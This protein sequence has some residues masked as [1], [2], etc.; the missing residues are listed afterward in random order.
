MYRVLCEHKFSTPLRKDQGAWWLD[1]VV[2]V[3]LDL[4]ETFKPSAKVAVH[5]FSPTSSEW[6]FL[7]FRIFASMHLVLSVFWI[8]SHSNR[9]VVSSHFNLHFPD[10]IY[11]ASFHVL[12]CHLYI[13]FGEVSVKVF[14]PFYKRDCLLSYSVL[15]VFCVFWIT[16]LYQMCL[17]QVFFP[18]YG[19]SS[20]S[21]DIVF[22]RA[23]VFIYYYY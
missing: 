22:Y 21:L 8:F 17:L 14:G 4:K 5:F 15:R 13:F 23:E 19:L 18:Y 12:I 2:R 10:G 1:Y 20:N 9:C 3:F 11:G 16:V 6:K 7:L